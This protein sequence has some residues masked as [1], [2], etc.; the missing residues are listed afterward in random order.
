MS[1]SVL[2]VDDEKAVLHALER[3]F[4]DSDY[5]VF[6]AESGEAGLKILEQEKIDIVVSDMRMPIMNGHQFLRRV[7]TLYPGTTRVVL[8][9]YANEHEMLE[10]IID[11]SHGLFLLKPWNN[12]E[13]LK[14]IEQIFKS[15]ELY[16]DLAMLE[17]VN[18]LDNLSMI[19][20][21]YNSV[22]Q[23]IEQDADVAAI[24]KVIETD[25]AVA[26]AVLR[27]INSAFYKIKTGSIIQAITYLG[28]AEVKAIVLSS[29]LFHAVNIQVP[30]FTAPR[31]AL[32]A[33]RTHMLVTA[34]FEK[35]LGRSVPDMG[36]TAGLLHNIGFV[37]FLHYYPEKYQEILQKFSNSKHVELS[38]LEKECFGIS[39]GQLGGYL[40]DWW[41][42]PYTI[43]ECALFHTNPGHEAV[44]DRRAVAAVHIAGNYAWENVL[45]QIHHAIDEEAFGMLG[46]NRQDFERILE[47]ELRR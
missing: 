47:R 40:L 6:F 37:M 25:P 5:E 27:V 29:S 9:G 39:H 1:K 15:R 26:A 14:K 28:L 41:G 31:L 38:T 13:L 24:A 23:L 8:S 21:I 35:L 19:P 34:I 3:S 44:M 7:K 36:A 20:G 2:F 16:R 32:H 30:S 11:G 10:S 22:C 33:N 45:P 12:E 18:K 43:V 42:L 4:F 17:F 46:T